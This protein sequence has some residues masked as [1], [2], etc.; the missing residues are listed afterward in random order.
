MYVY[1]HECMNVCMYVY[2]MYTCVHDI[3]SVH[4][5]LY[6]RLMHVI[7]YTKGIL[8][9]FGTTKVECMRPHIMYLEGM[10]VHLQ[11]HHV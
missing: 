4:N 11:V 3:P 10:H 6:T 8:Y 1:T 5:I 9:T 7:L 2:V